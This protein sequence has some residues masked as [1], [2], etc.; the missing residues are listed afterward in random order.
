VGVLV[1][2][3]QVEVEVDLYALKVQVVHYYYYCCNYY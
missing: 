2:Y 3:D 1:N